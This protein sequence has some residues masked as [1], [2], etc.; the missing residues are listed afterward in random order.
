M[1]CH[2][3]NEIKKSDPELDSDP[4]PELDPLVRGTDQGIRIRTKC[5]GSPTL[6]QPANYHLV[7]ASFNP[8][9]IIIQDFMKI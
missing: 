6:P 1:M 2:N 5:H 7:F 3:I 9:L 8:L 4:D